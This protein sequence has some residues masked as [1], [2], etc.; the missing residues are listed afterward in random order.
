MYGLGPEQRAGC[1]E[2]RWNERVLLIR[3]SKSPFAA[4]EGPSV[5]TAAGMAAGHAIQRAGMVV[6]RKKWKKSTR[7]REISLREGEWA[8][9]VEMP[10]TQ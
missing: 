1:P 3:P 9:Y 4:F 7:G 5:D 10:S 8:S 6:E 2:A